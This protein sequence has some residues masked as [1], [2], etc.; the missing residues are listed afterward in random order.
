MRR[1][2]MV[3]GGGNTRKRP[4]RRSAG[5]KGASGGAGGEVVTTTTAGGSKGAN[6]LDPTVV[7]AEGSGGRPFPV[8]TR[9]GNGRGLEGGVDLV[10]PVPTRGVRGLN[11]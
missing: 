11:G 3:G 10:D 2:R 4:G 7:V 9:C 8:I 1:R 5:A 6:H